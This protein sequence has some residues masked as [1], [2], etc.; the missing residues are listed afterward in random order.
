M[1]VCSLNSF[2]KR[3]V[4]DYYILTDTRFEVVFIYH[5]Q[6]LDQYNENFSIIASNTT[7]YYYNNQNGITNYCNPL[8]SYVVDNH[9]QIIDSRTFLNREN[10]DVVDISLIAYL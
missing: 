9:G 10:T 4:L 2:Y 7:S 6:F 3:Y 5:T 1:W 8:C